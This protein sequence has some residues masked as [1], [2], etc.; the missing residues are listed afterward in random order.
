M[1]RFFFFSAWRVGEVRTL[2]WRD[3]D[4]NDRVMRPR[5]EHSKNRPRTS[6]TGK[7]SPSATSGGCGTA[8]ARRMG[9]RG[10]YRQS[11]YW[12]ARGPWA[13]GLATESVRRIRVAGQRRGADDNQRSPKKVSRPKSDTA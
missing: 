9:S 7:A 8:R 12:R 4:K 3:Y 6:S 13:I 11:E 1:V 10:S 5:P 2:Q